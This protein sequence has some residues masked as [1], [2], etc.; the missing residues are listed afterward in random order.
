MRGVA[1]YLIAFPLMLVG[2]VLAIWL[3]ISAGTS[4]GHF[5]TG[6]A[7]FAIA[8]AVAFFVVLKIVNGTLALGRRNMNGWLA[9]KA[10]CEFRAAYDG[11]GIALDPKKRLVHLVSRFNGQTVEKTYS[12]DDVREW[13]F[14]IPGFSTIVPLVNSTVAANATGIYNAASV[15][16]AAEGTGFWV[17]VRDIDHPRW[18]IRFAAINIKAKEVER[19][20]DRWLEIF[21]R[22][23]SGDRATAAAS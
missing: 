17:K 8:A 14:E 5:L 4:T 3:G 1:A 6:F 12:F 22:H 15:T 16:K 11:D 9:S 18:F 20:L 19:Q 23:V 13:G 10:D 2:M 21:A 7:V